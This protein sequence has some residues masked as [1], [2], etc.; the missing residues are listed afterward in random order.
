MARIVPIKA[1]GKKQ[2]GERA[3][4]SILKRLLANVTD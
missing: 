3:A 1:E 4:I 2:K